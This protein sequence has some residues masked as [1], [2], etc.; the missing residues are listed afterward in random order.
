MKKST[1]RLFAAA[2]VIMALVFSMAGCGNTAKSGDDAAATVNDVV[3][4]QDNL[5]K[6]TIINM[7]LIGYDP[8]DMTEEL[9][10]TFLEGMVDIEVVK[11]YFEDSEKDIFDNDFK[12]ETKT[13]I[14]SAHETSEDFLTEYEISDEDLTRFF[15]SQLVISEM[16]AEIQAERP[17]ESIEAEVNAY[18]EE[19][20]DIFVD[21]EGNPMALDDVRQD[22]EYNIYNTY[23]DEKVESLKS[24][25][26]IEIAE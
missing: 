21:E 22:I 24:D 3:I 2:L 9:K 6:F 7:Y 1:G 13:F 8:A 18:Y 5:E 26:T 4:T 17:S 23:Y 11:Q 25:M 15:E 19:N 10:Q 20:K 14:S 12:E 16:Y